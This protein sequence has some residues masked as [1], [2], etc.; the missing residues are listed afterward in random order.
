MDGN[1]QKGF[2]PTS[3]PLRGIFLGTPSLQ[4]ANFKCSWNFD[5]SLTIQRTNIQA[6]FGGLL[7]NPCWGND[8]E[9]LMGEWDIRSLVW[10][11]PRAQQWILKVSEEQER[12]FTFIQPWIRGLDESVMICSDTQTH[13]ALLSLLLH[14]VSFCLLCFILSLLNPAWCYVVIQCFRRETSSYRQSKTSRYGSAR[15]VCG[16][17]QIWICNRGVCIICL[18]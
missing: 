2:T 11:I 3:D 18:H 9:S 5:Q 16:A 10:G 13:R 8:S 7:L 1:V 15:F 12:G 4:L 17:K 14:S 6:F